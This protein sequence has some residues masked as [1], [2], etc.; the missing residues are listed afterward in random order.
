MIHYSNIHPRLVPTRTVSLS[1]LDIHIHDNV[2]RQTSRD[3]NVLVFW[4]VVDL[5]LPDKLEAVVSIVLLK[6][7]YYAF[8]KWN[9]QADLFA[10]SELDL[11]CWF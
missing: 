6:H 2:E 4:C 8:R 1:G 9:A 3:S 10:V 5:I 11:V 7:P